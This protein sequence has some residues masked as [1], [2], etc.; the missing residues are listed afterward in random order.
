MYSYPFQIIKIY[1]FSKQMQLVLE[2]KRYHHKEVINN[3][4][5]I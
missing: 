4:V 1:K 5:I 3:S 2:I